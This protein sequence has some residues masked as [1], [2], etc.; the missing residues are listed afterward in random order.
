MNQTQLTTLTVPSWVHTATSFM[1]P[2]SVHVTLLTHLL[3]GY[4]LL[5]TI[6]TLSITH[7]SVFLVNHS[8]SRIF[9]QQWISRNLFTFR[10]MLIGTFLLNWGWG[11][12]WKSLW[13]RFWDTR[14]ILPSTY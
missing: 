3:T 9:T 8:I 14:Y 10:P 6:R 7:S 13:H 1:V 12:S 4:E 11:I 5:H 2:L